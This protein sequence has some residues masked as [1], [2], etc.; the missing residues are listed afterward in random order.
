MRI[1]LIFAFISLSTL[2]CKSKSK[3][4]TKTQTPAIET[5]TLEETSEA[6]INIVLN[7]KNE[8][9]VTGKVRFAQ[10]G[11]VV[12]IRETVPISKTKRWEVID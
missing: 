3:K 10:S 2:A 1:L 4:N 7:P 12:K 6:Y 5:T 8:S 9:N 11:D